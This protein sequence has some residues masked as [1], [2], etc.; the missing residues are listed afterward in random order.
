MPRTTH[1]LLLKVGAIATSVWIAVGIGKH[2]LSSFLDVLAHDWRPYVVS[3]LVSALCYWIV[4][5]R[6]HA[7]PRRL[8]AA[9]RTPVEPGAIRSPTDV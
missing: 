2:L 8:A 7:E 6:R 1:P 4:G 9:E 5:P 3:G